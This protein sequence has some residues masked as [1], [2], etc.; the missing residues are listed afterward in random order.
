[1]ILIGLEGFRYEYLA[2]GRY[3]EA[4]PRL[5]GL[6]TR[7][8][9]A[10]MIPVFPAR[11]APNLWSLVTGLYPVHHGIMDDVMYDSKTETYWDVHNTSSRDAP[12]WYR[13]DPFWSTYS[14]YGGLR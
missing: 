5:D 6:I 4:H 3:A 13:G 7:G 10:P 12:D 9:L 14:S 8:A 1:M 2:S 11:H